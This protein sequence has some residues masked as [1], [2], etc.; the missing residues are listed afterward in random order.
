MR[1]NTSQHDA[2]GS[3]V[4]LLI[5]WPFLLAWGVLMIVW[6]TITAAFGLVRLAA[7]WLIVV[8]VRRLWTR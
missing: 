5:A 2:G 7:H 1:A 6:A 8:P 4:L 3:G